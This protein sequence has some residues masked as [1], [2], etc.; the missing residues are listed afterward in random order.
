[1]TEIVITGD[2]FRVSPNGGARNQDRNISWLHC[3]L[4]HPVSV[5]TGAI[6]SRLTQS[7]SPLSYKD[8]YDASG[9]SPSLSAWAAI[10]EHLTDD[11]SKRYAE[12]FRGK[13]VIGFELSDAMCTALDRNN[14]TYISILIHPVRFLDDLAFA[15]RTNN[16]SIHA[17][18]MDVSIPESLCFQHAGFISAYFAARRSWS[19]APPY[20]LFAA[21]T[22]NDRSLFR[23]GALTSQSWIAD[24]LLETYQNDDV[25]AFKH[26]PLKRSDFVYNAVR[27]KCVRTYEVNANVYS[28]LSDP[29]LVDIT[30]V[31]SSVGVE[32][33]YFGKTATFLNKPF[34]VPFF[35]GDDAAVGAPLSCGSEILSADFWRTVLSPAVS[36]TPMDGNQPMYRPDLLRATIGQDWNFGDLYAD[37]MVRSSPLGRQL[38]QPGWRARLKQRVKRLLGRR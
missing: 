11:I 13:I 7:E 1:M 31:S 16:Q 37:F 6:P 38:N 33:K 35:R 4:S 32:A 9:L 24:R 14:V 17:R 28:L 29:K 26:H 5:A 18:L 22:H 34:L 27:K 20:R 3:I 30:T 36:V 10:S 2:I 8:A 19:D 15:I 12:I 25:I 21:Q 23:D